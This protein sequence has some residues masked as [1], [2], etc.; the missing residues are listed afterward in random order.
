[1][2]FKVKTYIG[3]SLFKKGIEFKISELVRTFL[4]SFMEGIRRLWQFKGIIK[5]IQ[6]TK[7]YFSNFQETYIGN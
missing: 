4:N 7:F 2:R 6:G 3:K 1:L 5:T